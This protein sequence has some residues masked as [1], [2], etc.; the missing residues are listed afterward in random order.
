MYLKGFQWMSFFLN[1]FTNLAEEFPS[2][3]SDIERIVS[4]TELSGN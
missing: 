1:A 3:G 4:Q 2:L